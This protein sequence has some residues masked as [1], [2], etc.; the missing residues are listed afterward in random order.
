M[1]VDGPTLG[2]LRNP[3]VLGRSRCRLMLALLWVGYPSQT[4]HTH[5]SNP[6]VLG[7]ESHVGGWPYSGTGW[8]GGPRGLGAGVQLP[9]DSGP[10]LGGS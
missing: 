9:I 4:V 3:E 8:I 10:A 5:W 2:G 6:E 7:R 1:S